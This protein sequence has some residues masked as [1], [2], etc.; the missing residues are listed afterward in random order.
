MFHNVEANANDSGASRRRQGGY[1]GVRGNG[2]Y[3]ERQDGYNETRS[4]G[5]PAD[6]GDRREQG[7]FKSSSNKL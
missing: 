5:M 7:G 1:N 4:A 2:R 3:Q 6:N